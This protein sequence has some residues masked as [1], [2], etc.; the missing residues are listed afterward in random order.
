MRRTAAARAAEAGTR[1]LSIIVSD[2][3]T[4]ARRL[5]ERTGYR[6]VARRAKVKDDWQNPGTEWVLL[7]KGA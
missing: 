6:E 2:S 3:N 4:G 1:G 5:Y 7:L